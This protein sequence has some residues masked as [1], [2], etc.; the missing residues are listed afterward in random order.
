MKFRPFPGL[1]LFTVIAL[2]IL[3]ALG[4]WQVKRLAWKSELIAKIEQAAN[5]P[6]LRGLREINA[7]IVADDPLEFRRVSLTGKFGGNVFHLYA[8]RVE[9][10]NQKGFGWHPIRHFIAEDARILVRDKPFPDIEKATPP[11][12]PQ[13]TVTING[14]IRL[15]SNQ[16]EPQSESTPSENRWFGM[17][18]VIEMFYSDDLNDSPYFGI[19]EFF[20]DLESLGV[21]ETPLP[22]KIPKLPN[23]HL[24]YLL[25]WYGFA[26]ILFIIYIILHVREG[27]L[28]FRRRDS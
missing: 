5:A 8:P 16:G 9:Q 18:A 19:R 6:A 20:I 4:T 13:G 14:Y 15:T 26:L 28:T 17:K 21:R 1:T 23:R 10:N 24:E 25:T 3:I 22:V 27:R 7:A 11:K 12:A 2:A